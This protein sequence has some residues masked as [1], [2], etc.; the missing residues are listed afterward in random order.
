MSRFPKPYVNN[1]R[2][3]RALMEYVPFENTSIGSRKSGTPKN[4]KKDD[5]GIDHVGGTAGGSK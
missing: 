3:D 2:V 4:V 5:M 1:T